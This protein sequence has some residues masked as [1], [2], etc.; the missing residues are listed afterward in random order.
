MELDV[1]ASAL[2]NQLRVRDQRGMGRIETPTEAGAANI[3][4]LA[5]LDASAS[6]IR[7]W[8]SSIIPGNLQ[9]P[10]YSQA[11]ITRAHPRLPAMEVNRR[12]RLKAERAKVFLGR[13]LDPDLTGAYFVIGERAITQ[14]I[15]LG[16]GGEVHA[17]Q[18]QHLLDLAHAHAISIR[19]LADKTVTPGLAD[20][21]A[22]Y[23]LDGQHKVGYVETIMG[24]WYSARTQDVDKLHSCFSEISRE[25]MDAEPSRTFIREVLES[26]RSLRK[27]SPA[28][29][30]K[31]K[32]S[33]SRLTAAQ[34][35]IVSASPEHMRAP[36]RMEP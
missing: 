30:P 3:D 12:V 18:L 31:E 14:C 24:S 23:T 13:L 35:T 17:S 9:V 16:D 10:S 7:V 8:D 21:F 27:Q 15:N 26:W 6:F 33:S 1:H 28:E 5:S 2:I 34:E 29:P 32:T 25:A 11:V 19:V 22:L 4:R 36:W 20:Q